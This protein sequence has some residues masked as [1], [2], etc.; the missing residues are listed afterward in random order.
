MEHSR[1]YQKM[2]GLAGCLW[3]GLVVMA[4]A[5]VNE[6][7]RKSARLQEEIKS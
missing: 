1:P 7:L 4:L 3:L 2:L 6:R 5:Q